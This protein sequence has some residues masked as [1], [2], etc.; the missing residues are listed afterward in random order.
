LLCFIIEDEPGIRQVL[1][2]GSAPRSGASASNLAALHLAGLD[3]DAGDDRFGARRIVRG[4][5][6]ADDRPFLGAASLGSGGVRGSRARHPSCGNG[7]SGLGRSIRSFR[8]GVGRARARHALARVDAH[9]VLPSPCSW[10]GRF[11][12]RRRQLAVWI[13]PRG[14]A[15]P[16][17]GTI[18]M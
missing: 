12:S 16:P 10:R 9:R 15:V 1:T 4:R 2:A 18:C 7:C 5:P 8:I 6:P 17:R 13:S 3:W 11:A 14:L